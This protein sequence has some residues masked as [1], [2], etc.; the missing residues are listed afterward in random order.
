MRW[1]IVIV[2]L[3]ISCQ[4]LEPESSVSY[5]VEGTAAY[6]DIEYLDYSGIMRVLDDYRL[7]FTTHMVGFE[8]YQEYH[9][10]AQKIGEAGWLQ[11]KVEINGEAQ[12][13][14]TTEPYGMVKI[15]GKVPR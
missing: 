1:L 11:I 3:I 10:K 9:L 7:P 15:A 6:A 12:K 2:C 8:R 4:I 13:K 5:L 14:V